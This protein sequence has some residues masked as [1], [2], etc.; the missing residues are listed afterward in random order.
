MKMYNRIVKYLRITVF[1]LFGISWLP[2]YADIAVLPYKVE[3]ADT[4]FTEAMGSEY[5]KLVALAMYI[6]KGISI[7]SHD[8]LEKDMHEFS[9]DPQGVVAGYKLDTLGKARSIDRIQIGT[10]TK[11]SRGFT[12]K[13]L[14]YDVAT[15]KIVSRCNEYADTLYNVAIAEMR[16]LYLSYPDNNRA[17]QQ[18]IYDIAFVVDNSY[19]ASREW[20]SIK[21]GIVALCDTISD[22]W[23]DMRVYV[24]PF[25]TQSKKIGTYAVTGATTL[26][27]VL[28]ELSLAKGIVT[29][30]N[31]CLQYIA[32]GLPWRNEAKKL[33]IVVA[34]SRCDYS[35]AR[36]LR[37]LIKKKGITLY[38]IGTGGL[39]HTERTALSF[40]GDSYYD[41]TYRQRMY[42]VYGNPVDVFCEA[43]RIFHGDAGDRWKAGVTAAKTKA[44]KP[45]V[46][47]VFGVQNALPYEL[48]AL[49]PKQTAIKILNAEVLENNIV[50][51]CET[52]AHNNKLTGQVI[53]RVLIADGGYSLWLPVADK[54]ILNYLAENQQMRMY[55]GI[56]PKQDL[57]APYGVGLLPVAV[58]GL[59]GSHIPSMLKLTV[60][61]IIQR[62]QWKGFFNP[63]LWFVPVTVKQIIPLSGE[64]DIR[65]K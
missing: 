18:S 41:V 51:I 21:Q 36:S 19:S 10:L 46:A 25:L 44:A 27:D 49:Y 7:Y 48:P 3:S 61:D 33:C 52:I 37:Y 43:G 53:A 6:Q 24:V 65:N 17:M 29:D 22:N 5:A 56:S 2:V 15:G 30:I 13:S 32:K 26:D 64:E 9:I 45:F 39:T 34:A 58:V 40:I 4:S 31:P 50:D 54:R 14:L 38:V 59:P 23:N 55:V 63:P 12:V 8:L 11:T 47:E 35:N 62:P 57:G 28:Q 60:K 16:S 20:K 42:D 1:L